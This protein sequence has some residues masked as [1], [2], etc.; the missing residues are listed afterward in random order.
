MRLM[1]FMAKGKK[2][3]RARKR[4]AGGRS[5]K[6]NYETVVLRIPSP[7]RA[8]VEAM[9]D[10]FHAENEAYLALPVAGSFWEVLGVSSGA[11]GEEVKQA[12]R[13]LARL[14]HPDTNKRTDA[15]ERFTAV[16]EAYEAF[17]G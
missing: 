9:I 5:H 14:Y 16:N 4:P 11:S 15:H 10:R 17:L 7:L 8:E 1:R 6:G 3:Q 2:S 12:Y 13:K